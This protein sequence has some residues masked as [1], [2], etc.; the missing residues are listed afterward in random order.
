M[1]VIV[2]RI[3]VIPA[4]EPG[5][6]CHSATNRTFRFYYCNFTSGSTEFYCLYL[7]KLVFTKKRKNLKNISDVWSFQEFQLMFKNKY[8]GFSVV[9]FFIYY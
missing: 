4:S 1:N 3:R 9:E 7:V 6:G 8:V 2:L 5:S